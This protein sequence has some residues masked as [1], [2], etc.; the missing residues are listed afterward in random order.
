[1]YDAF[2]CFYLLAGNLRASSHLSL[3]RDDVSL[4]SPMTSRG[5]RFDKLSAESPKLSRSSP[6]G[7]VSS[8]DSLL[9]SDSVSESRS[10]FDKVQMSS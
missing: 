10:R 6:T 5:I 8:Q 4:G 1:M 2:F 9:S 7:S 3:N